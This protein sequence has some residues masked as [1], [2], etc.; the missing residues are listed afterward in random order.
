MNDDQIAAAEEAQRRVNDAHSVL[1][2]LSELLRRKINDPATE[3]N[4]LNALGPS[5][6]EFIAALDV[7]RVLACRV[8]VGKQAWPRGRE[9]RAVKR[10]PLT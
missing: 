3:L 5:F 2:S 7:L 4:V 9:M 1:M 10:E 8:L 6:D